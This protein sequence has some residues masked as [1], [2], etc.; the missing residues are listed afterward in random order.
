MCG[1]DGELNATSPSSCDQSHEHDHSIVFVEES[2]RLEPHAVEGLEDGLEELPYSFT[3]AP[4]PGVQPALGKPQ[5]D[6]GVEDSVD[7]VVTAA[8]PNRVAAPKQFDVL[9]RHD[10]PSIVLIEKPKAHRRDGLRR[11]V[12]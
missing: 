5:L 1:A 6:L 11:A 4:N 9:P 7:G 2:L 10:P 3:A 8:V 12:A